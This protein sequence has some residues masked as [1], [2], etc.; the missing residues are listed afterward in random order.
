MPIDPANKTAISLHRYIPSEY[1]DYMNFNFDDEHLGWYDVDGNFYDCIPKTKW[2]STTDYKE[3]VTKFDI[4]K[5][6]F[7]DK[8][9]PVI[10]GEVGMLT[11][12]KRDLDSIKEFLYAIL[13]VSANYKGIMTCLWDI[14]EKIGNDIN[15]YNRENNQW[16]D[17]KLINCINKIS[18]AKYINIYE[19]YSMSNIEIQ[20]APIDE[21]LNINL[22]IR[23]PLK[24]M[25]NVKLI[26]YKG[27][28]LEF[29]I[30]SNDKNTEFFEINCGEENRKKEY[31]GTTT[32]T[33][34]VSKEDC[35][36]YIRAS[37]FWG[38]ENIILNNLT[39]EFNESFIVINYDS[40]K[41]DVY[42]S[43]N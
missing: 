16:F 14:S 42:K 6:I 23:K 26:G 10:I 17:E 11:E 13:S 37:V 27:I 12:Q 19:Y 32:Y 30:S 4:L 36:E 1:L 15:Y 34:D 39:V 8:N 22:G 28:D 2:G 38:H 18:R 9:I 41:S 35:H 24:I 40:F 7:T 20:P 25:I 31:D 5:Y 43:I 29:M 33:I 3:L 21:I